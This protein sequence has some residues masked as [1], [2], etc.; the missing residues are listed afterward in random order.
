MRKAREALNAAL[1]QAM[2]MIMQKGVSQATVGLTIELE[3][4][5]E[6][7]GSW[8]PEISYKT[9]VRVPL[10]IKQAGREENCRQVYWDQERLCYMMRVDGEQVTMDGMAQ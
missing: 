5:A 8:E 10:D 1:T 7:T 6:D 4:D 2:I 9:S 3:M